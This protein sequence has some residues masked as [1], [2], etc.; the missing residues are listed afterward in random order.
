MDEVFH[1]TVTH[2]R[3]D[4]GMPNWTGVFS[5]EDFSKILIFL[6]SVQ[7]TSDDSGH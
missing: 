5:E 7:I 6:H 4:K 3:P 1:T 2:G